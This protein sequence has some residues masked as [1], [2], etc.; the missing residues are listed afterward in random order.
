MG[1]KIR[2][3]VKV[4]WVYFYKFYY[5]DE[6]GKNINVEQVQIINEMGG[7]IQCIVFLKFYYVF[8]IVDVEGVEVEMLEIIFILYERIVV[9]EVVVVGYQNFFELVYENVD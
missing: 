3:G 6:S 4:E 8:N 5:K 1:G 7:E 2:K 9:C